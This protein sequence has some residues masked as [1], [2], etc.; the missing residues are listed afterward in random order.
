V[1]FAKDVADWFGHGKLN[2]FIQVK[3]NIKNGRTTIN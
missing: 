1:Y 3:L 2:V